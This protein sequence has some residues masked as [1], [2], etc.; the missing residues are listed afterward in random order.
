M[1]IRLQLLALDDVGFVEGAYALLLGRAVDPEGMAHY[2]GSLRAGTPKEAVLADIENSGEAQ[3]YA[4]NRPAGHSRD[5]QA[6][7][8]NALLAIPED[9]EF[10]ERS[11]VALTGRGATPEASAAAMLRLARHGR[12][13]DLL[14]RWRQS[15]DGRAHASELTDVHTLDL[16]VEQ[17]GTS[18]SCTLTD[19]LAPTDEAF[20]HLAYRR[21][22]GR[23]SDPMGRASYL[24]LL[25]S[26]TSRLWI[27]KQLCDSDEGRA[28]GV[29]LPGLLEAIENPDSVALPDSAAA[30][31]DDG[32][33]EG[34]L[35][36]DLSAADAVLQPRTG[37]PLDAVTDRLAERFADLGTVE[38]GTIAATAPTTGQAAAPVAA[39]PVCLERFVGAQAQGWSFGGRGASPCSLSYGGRIIGSLQLDQP[40]PDLRVAHGLESEQVGFEALLGGVLQFSALARACDVL[41]LEQPDNAGRAQDVPLH[42]YLAEALSFSPLRAFGRLAP[43][44]SVGRLLAA[45]LDAA[46]EF[47]LL[48][49]AASSAAPEPRSICVDLYQEGESGSLD[50][51]ARFAIELTGQVVVMDTPLLDEYAPVLVV[52]TDAQRQVVLTDCV[53]LPAMHSIQQRPLID[54]HSV[55][56]GGQGA[57][58]VAAKIGRSHLDAAIRDHL[59]A[60][61]DGTMPARRSTRV[62][63]YSRDH[64]DFT[65]EVEL[66]PLRGYADH[67]ACLGTD[68]LV[69][70][71]GGQATSLDRFLSSE[72]T[73]HVLFVEFR[74]RMRPD[75]W[76][77][78]AQNRTRLGAGAKL[79]HWQSIWLEGTARPYLAKPG[80]LLHPAFDQHRLLPLHTALVRRDTVLAALAHD[81]GQFRSGSLRLEQAFAALAP[82]ELSDVPVPLDTVTWLTAPRQAVR[83]ATEQLPVPQ[84][85]GRT[86]ATAPQPGVS[87]IVNYR[88]SPAPTIACLESLRRQVYG[89]PIEVVLVN[90]L[91]S[92]DSVDAVTARACA[93]FG[94]EAVRTIDYPLEFNHSA[95]C[96]LA[97]KAARHDLLLMLSN[98]SLL[99]TDDALALVAGVAMVPWVGTAGFR[100]IGGPVGQR[101]L[102][103]LGLGTAKRQFLFQGGSPLSTYQ[104]P[105]FLYSHTIE[106]LGNTFAAVIV[107]RDIYFA[108]GGLDEQVF[109]TNFNDVDFCCRAMQRGYRHVSVGSAVVEH[110]G[111]GSRESDLDLPL[112]QR[113]LER[114]PDLAVLARIGLY[115]L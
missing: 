83:M 11:H 30:T 102:Q 101:K 56:V 107:R 29:Q 95:Q 93:L 57:L 69:R 59:Q 43:E 25:R 38:A 41:R 24:S 46:G 19:L 40:R 10:I 5:P 88:N 16:S 105:Q 103:S 6:L 61:A 81:A 33:E 75:F 27:L 74:A 48:F 71:A 20:V 66:R 109:P 23:N 28:H 77:A 108:M 26:G 98:D 1:N 68:G 47:R 35:M 72:D 99:L 65:G 34:D 54:Y 64:Y 31:L 80:H 70:E 89:G 32:A 51:L 8:V 37:S 15:A 49:E 52:V 2:I 79:V 3:A 85:A 73:R 110:V 100:I 45:D 60:P 14:R 58:D 53:P 50:R 18:D 84:T 115:Q 111:R 42:R 97:A 39:P 94:P 44:R 78:I 104:P 106:T 67:L 91:S 96:N 13:I 82:N 76:A 114:C 17:L 112:D 9:A 12:R 7:T 87:V 55:L 22:L 21:L 90:N 62:L 92:P 113:I 36:A 63:L 86:P 4:L